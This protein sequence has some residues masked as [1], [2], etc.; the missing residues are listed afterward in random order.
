MRLS[1]VSENQNTGYPTEIRRGSK[2]G[3]SVVCLKNHTYLVRS[4]ILT[5]SDI[6]VDAEHL[7]RTC[8]FNTTVLPQPYHHLLGTTYQVLSRKLR[9]CAVFID[10]LFGK[11][12]NEGLPV[13][14]CCTKVGIVC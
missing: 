4:R 2:K 3:R 8:Q 13:L 14:L 7:E 12:L 6:S 11:T 5:E 1:F 9:D 10:D